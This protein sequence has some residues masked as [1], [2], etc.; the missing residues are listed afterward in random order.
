MFG[1]ELAL[2]AHV[3]FVEVRHVA[4]SLE[5]G[6]AFE[7]LGQFPLLFHFVSKQMFNLG[8]TRNASRQMHIL[9]VI[10]AEARHAALVSPVKTPDVTAGVFGLVDPSPLHSP[11]AQVDAI[12]RTGRKGTYVATKYYT[13][14]GEEPRF[15]AIATLALFQA[16]FN[17]FT[18]REEFF[19]VAGTLDHMLKAYGNHPG[20]WTLPTAA[21]S[22][23]NEAFTAA[24]RVLEDA[25]TG[26]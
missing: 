18:M 10:A 17:Q 19:L 9:R 20:C 21:T 8:A 11:V 3:R 1:D 25:L 4:V 6:P 13:P 12:L 26:G 2:A 5:R 7:P 22:V 24:G 14:R 16:A 15:G 23:P